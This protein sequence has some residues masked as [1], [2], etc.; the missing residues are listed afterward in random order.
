MMPKT[1]RLTFL[2]LNDL[3]GYVEPHREL[4]RAPDG[5][6]HATMG[7]LARIASVFDQVR[8]DTDGAVVALD[9]GDTFH[10]TFPAVEGR[11]EGLVD[12]MNA[13]AFDAMTVHWE[14]AYGPQR[15]RELASQLRYPVLAINVY[16]KDSGELEFPPYRVVER[17]GLRVAIIGL[18]CP[19]VDKTMP[20]AF[21]EGIRFT[22][23]RE[24]LPR[25]IAHV[26]SAERADL[27]VLLSHLGFA[28][29]V[30]MA[31][32]VDGIDILVSG[33]THNRMRRPAIENGAIIFQSGCHGSF[34]GRLDVDVDDGR[35]VDHRHELV[36]I[37][38]SL[39]QEPS[40]LARVEALMAPHRKM[41]ARVVGETVSTLDRY[42]MYQ[43]SMDDV[44]LDAIAETSGRDIAFSNGWRYG[45]PIAPGP[46]T[47]DDL[48]NVIPTNPFVSTVELTGTEIR[49]M[50]EAN[51][52]RVFAADAFEQ[53][54]G[55]VKRCRGLTMYVK[56]ENPHPHRIER[57]FIDGREARD[58]AI[59]P[60]A[61]VTS[62]GV[63]GRFGR[64]RRNLEVRAIDALQKHFERT[65]PVRAP[66]RRSVI[67]I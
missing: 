34:V 43:A 45:A 47:I 39:A 59:Y 56:A 37:G 2:Q 49:E 41:L 67:A 15:V 14:Y 6:R 24:E 66:L 31:R 27:V 53:M 65:K 22:I 52:E 62:Q 63:P 16:R 38:E 51:L 26:R 60:A 50:L 11:G 21:S 29:D 35:V 25:W 32:E 54:G 46:V 10:G 8:R 5:Q 42:S 33:H 17:A 44:L 57:L 48:W 55:Y 36:E 58:D 13:L 3:H 23:G 12:L 20:P 19:I 40:M 4:V 28:Q 9:N 61:F 30:K 7:G 18:A 1:A 64:N